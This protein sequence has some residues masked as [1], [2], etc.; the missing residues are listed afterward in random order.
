MSHHF[1]NQQD[2]NYYIF[3]NFLLIN[4]FFRGTFARRLQ[5]RGSIA[6]I[7]LINHDSESLQF[8]YI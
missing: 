7:T 1:C 5:N 6:L 4:F 2:A 8:I 3:M